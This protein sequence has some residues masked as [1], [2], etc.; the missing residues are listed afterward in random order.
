MELTLVPPAGVRAAWP[1]ILQSLQAVQAK[2]ADDW[3][4]EDV[5]HALKSGEAACHLASGAS[6]FCGILITTRAV[7]EFSG[8]PALHVWIVH[9]TGPADVLEAG[10]PLLRDMAR[11]GGFTRITFGSPRPGWAKRFPLVSAIYAIPM[12]AT[13]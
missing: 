9:N 1:L 5:Y 6:G 8:T 10:L 7:A 2:T 13:Q 4:P 12:E 3:I 11:K